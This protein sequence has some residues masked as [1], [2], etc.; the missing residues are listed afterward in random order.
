MLTPFSIPAST[1]A[2][3]C[4]TLVSLPIDITK[5]RIQTMKENTYKNPI[6]CVKKT[7]KAEGILSLW[8]GFTPYFMRLG[9]QSILT[10]G[11]FE[12]AMKMFP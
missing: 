8:K 7:V 11:F 4:A 12:L 3:F 6:D 5:T 1:F 10:W 9:P 2:G